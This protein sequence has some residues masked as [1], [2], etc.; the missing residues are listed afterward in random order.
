[1]QTFSCSP[2]DN[3]EEI[4]GEVEFKLSIFIYL[5][6]RLF[7]SLQAAASLDII[8]MIDVGAAKYVQRL[9]HPFYS[10]SFLYTLISLKAENEVCGGQFGYAGVCSPETVCLRSLGK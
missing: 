9:V 7:F 5:D 2:C 3:P 1:M 4:C 6:L 8:H 10:C